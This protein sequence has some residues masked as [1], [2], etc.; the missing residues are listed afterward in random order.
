MR[1]LFIR[2]IA[3]LNR[4]TSRA[5][6]QKDVTQLERTPFIIR[7]QGQLDK[8]RTAARLRRDLQQAGKNQTITVDA[9]VSRSSLERSLDEARQQIHAEPIEIPITADSA[10]LQNAGQAQRD[11]INSGSGLRNVI[12]NYV[13]WNRVLDLVVQAMKKAVSTSSELAK[14]QTEL[15][16]VTGKSNSEMQSLMSGY[17][18]LAQ[19]L[20]VTTTDIT[21][22][23]DEWLRTGKS[24]SDTEK[25]IT[26]STILAKIGQLD[27]AEATKYL[28][29]MMKGFK[30][31][32]D[33]VI[34]IVDR[35]NA[36]D[37]AAA[38][39]SGGLAEAMSKC[40]NSAEIA[41]ISMDS[42]VG[43]IAAVK[44]VTQDSDSVVGNAFKSMF[45]RMGNVKL[46]KFI[47]E[48]GEDISGEINNVEKLL[49]HFG[50]SLR[51][52]ATE[53]RDFEDVIY[54]VGMAWD[55]F[56]SV[57]KNTIASTFGGTYQREKVTAL[58]ENFDRALELTEVS[59]NSAGTA[60]KKYAVYQDGLEASVNRLTSAF[61]SLAYNTVSQDFLKGLADGAA[62]IVAFVDKTKLIQTSLT[63]LTFTGAVKGLLL[64]GTRLVAVKANLNDVTTAMGLAIRSEQLNAAENN[65]LAQSFSRL[66]TAQQNLVLSSKKL[67]TEQRIA[68]LTSTGLT[69][70]E[71]EAR[72]QT[73]GLVTAENTAAKA[74]FNLR[75]AWEAL[76]VSIASNPIGLIV[77]ALTSATMI[78]SACTEKQNEYN[79]KIQETAE[80]AKQEMSEISDLY[81]Q[82]RDLSKEVETDS[83]KKT[84]LI[85]VTDDLLEKLGYEKN[86][87]D[88][89]IEKY[90]NLDDAINAI[91]LGGL[92]EAEGSL[93]QA[94]GLAESSLLSDN[95][96]K[97]FVSNG[98]K[99]LRYS[100]QV[101]S[102]KINND[103]ISTLRKSGLLESDSTFGI[104]AGNII[105]S[106][107][108]NNLNDMLEN[109]QKISDMIILLNKN[110][111]SELL[112][113]DNIYQSLVSKQT[114]LKNK[115]D[116]YNSAI[117]DLND[118]IAQQQI[119]TSLMGKELPST[120]EE[121]DKFKDSLLESAESSE[122]WSNKF[123][124]GTDSAKEAIISAL[125]NKPEFI[126][127]FKNEIPDATDDAD[128][129]LTRVAETISNLSKKLDD[130][131][132][133]ADVF[134]TALEKIITG[135]GFTAKEVNELFALAPDL[136]RNVSKNEDGTYTF[137]K[138]A[139]ISSAEKYGESHNPYK[140]AY[141]KSM[142]EVT[143]L[144]KQLSD[145]EAMNNDP[146]ISNN[147]LTQQINDVKSQLTSAQKA[148]NASK[149][150]YDEYNDMIRQSVDSSYLKNIDTSFSTI[151][152]EVKDK[153]G[154][155]NTGIKNLQKAIDSIA[156]GKA[157][158]YDS[159]TELI[160]SFPEL[161][162]KVREGADGFYIESDALNYMLDISYKAR[163]EFIEN[164][165][166]KTSNAI[167][168]AQHRIQVWQIELNIL[169][170]CGEL[171]SSRAKELTKL[172]DSANKS[173]EDNKSISEWLDSLTGK[174][175]TSTA[176]TSTDK[177][178]STE[179]Q[180]QID[181]YDAIIQA[182]EALSD[183]KIKALEDEKDAIGKQIDTLEDEK[184]AIRDK[185]DEQQRELDLIEAQNNLDKAKKQKV[186]VYK[187]GQGLVQV[188]DEKAVK[189]A[190]KN[191]DDV[192][193]DI[194]EAKI[195]KQIDSLKK[196]Q[197]G[198]DDQINGWNAYKDSFSDMESNAKDQLA[199]E[200]AK[201]AL[202][203]D[204]NELLNLDGKTASEIQNGLAEAIYNKD[205]Y[206]NKDNSKYVT[207]TFDDFLKSLGANVNAD[208]FSRLF[209]SM[210][211]TR[212]VPLADKVGN[213]SE[214][215]T[216]NSS[217]SNIFNK[218]CEIYLHPTIEINN[219]TNPE[220]VTGAIKTYLNKTLRTAIN[221]IK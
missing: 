162:D 217:V 37:M 121:F 82:Y 107:K 154:D 42:L 64:L 81:S 12:Q 180:N 220:E 23:A 172:I 119:L 188:Q 175:Y 205:V 134:S 136:F 181:Y 117:S 186:F 96:A 132:D 6:I 86:A 206:D 179:L 94:Y 98:D 71:A 87:V 3:S 128:D 77:T 218:R 170:K 116:S 194:E 152:T 143:D 167:E 52:S 150:L 178:V 157:L 212:P 140:E 27:T 209:N 9:K 58:F 32:T 45:S 73:I 166:V 147:G 65:L 67:S 176:K 43:Y 184:E 126:E 151:T 54:D 174:V 66:T 44:E 79:Q 103:I 137:D 129:G 165:K 201:K 199:I 197:D 97:Y 164:E 189:D 69:R 78:I 101:D 18:A 22:A 39:T 51:T 1:E 88:D 138:N 207:V 16:I 146:R 141:E 190:Q 182:V 177:S 89:L 4:T 7:L 74:T 211:E 148:F 124:G 61:E 115:V 113:N 102:G 92:E 26:D 11:I 56:S 68:I 135:V 60:I 127:F 202:G 62:G 28:T 204:E 24:I 163:N 185:N 40:A 221:S 99:L 168:Q 161:N 20:S 48:N 149:L 2:L 105:L 95:P 118:N 139:V 46:G 196:D 50:I 93:K 192:N 41:N 85:K 38:V 100:F 155:Y 70:A 55:K 35:L 63:A 130:F 5:N 133:S 72:L 13:N 156:N 123:V 21:S 200:Q 33:D 10:A 142:Q 19:D 173:I 109:Y 198:I 29:S 169:E 104:D 80:Q 210:Y 57:E 59:A 83:D 106:G 191:L 215:V 108:M 34:G 183:K 145:L 120:Q 30:V 216:N 112:K 187:E 84:D 153:V 125:K 17:N 114:E 91:T 214:N 203:V 36:V 15:Q 208:G 111:S 122:E 14:A 8:S 131:M 144:E 47:D 158:D 159:I 25:L 213:S 171:E 75:G 219:P 53:F 90:G 160:K 76:K 49:S 110:Y 195:D 31:E 193:A